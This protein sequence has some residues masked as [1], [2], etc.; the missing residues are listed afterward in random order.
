MSD[1]KKSKKKEQVT[2]V[3][4]PKERVRN[5]KIPKRKVAALTFNAWWLLA[6]KQNGFE[7]PMKE[8]V[9]KHFKSRGFIENG[10]FDDGLRDFGVK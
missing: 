3:G 9:Y 8:I 1:T 6:Q 2:L 5:V 4:Q 10:K 7:N